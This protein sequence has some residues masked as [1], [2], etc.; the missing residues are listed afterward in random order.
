LNT[1]YKDI[2]SNHIDTFV[3][4]NIQFDD[5]VIQ[6]EMWREDMF[7]ILH[8]FRKLIRHCTMITGTLK[9]QR[10]P[11]LA[12]LYYSYFGSFP[13]ECH[14]ADIDVELCSKIYFAMVEAGICFH[15]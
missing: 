6:S 7:E 8:N 15:N 13:T 2:I 12:N 3:A 4:H 11:R 10:W 1:L 14:R 9:G 5:A